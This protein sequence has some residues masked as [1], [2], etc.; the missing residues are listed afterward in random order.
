MAGRT[1][2]ATRRRTSTSARWGYGR[3]PA[4]RRRT[5]GVGPVAVIGRGLG[6]LWMGLA[7]GVGWIVR[8]VGRQA[9]TARELDPEHRRDGGGLLVL[10]LAVVLG[11]AVYTS[12]AGPLGQWL[13]DSV[14]LFFGAIAVALPLLLLVGAVRLMREPAEAAHRGRSIV[15]W[16]ALIIAAAGMLH[17]GQQPVDQA[18]RGY[19]GGLIGLGVGGLLERAVT[20]WVAYPL[21]VLLLLFGLL[22][23]TATPISRIPTRLAQLRDIL[24]G[25]PFTGSTVDD[26]EGAA[27]DEDEED[28][29]ARRPLRRGSVRRR[30]GSFVDADEPDGAEV[31]PDEIIRDTVLLSR[32]GRSRV[33]AARRVVGPPD[34]TPSPTRAEQLAI[35]GLGGDYVLPPT[36]LLRPGGVPRTRSKANDEVIAALSGVFDQFDVDAAVT[37]FARGPTVTRYEVELGHGVKVER[38]TQLSRNIAY[39][40]KSPDVRILSPIPGKS[41]VGIEIPNADRDDVALGD[42]LRSRA[43]TAD[44]HPMLVALGK[45]IEGGYVV[46]NLAKM[47]HILIA[48]ATGAGKALA[49]DTPVPTPRGWTTMGALQVGDQVFDE[50][51]QPCT[52]IAATPVMHGRPCYEV[53]F[54]DGTVIVADAQHQWLTTTR[55]GRTQRMHEWKSGSYWPDGD[56]ARVASRTSQVLAEPDRP[57]TT[58]ELLD[59]VGPQFRN[60]VYRIAGTIPKLGSV[61]GTTYRRGGRDVVRFVPAYS[62]HLLYEALH[63]LVAS[64]GRSSQRRAFDERPVTTAEI[65][66]SLHVYG[67]SGVWTNHAVPVCGPLSYPEQDLPI[68]PYTFGAWLGDGTTGSA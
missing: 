15:G 59:E 21:L 47:P 23:V 61:R 5:A 58:S 29:D 49:L 54:S 28:P 35:T 12:N 44:H 60:V 27:A 8:A 55:A 16:S 3:T 22:V 7:H 20:Q 19:A 17:L 24:L 18:Q 65:A 39:A 4:G 57:A 45:D 53:E 30:Q 14:R 48:G 62:R 34:H 37:G 68:A 46:A 42:V 9:A 50:R 33:P 56:V 51:G 66:A 36:N 52:I 6:A 1:S 31:E 41:A 64:P 2:Q 40:V 10:G 43:A 63:D 11:V 32:V 25:K 26:Q 38:I 67:K 13:A